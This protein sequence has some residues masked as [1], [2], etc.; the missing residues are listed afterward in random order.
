MRISDWSSDVCSSDL[1]AL[2]HLGQGFGKQINIAALVVGRKVAT[3]N[4]LTHRSQ[5]RFKLDD[6]IGSDNA[7]VHPKIAHDP[8]HSL[9]VLELGLIAVKI[10]YAALKVLVLDAQFPEHA[11]QSASTV[12]RHTH[13]GAYVGRQPAGQALA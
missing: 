5:G 2:G 7:A 12:F 1:G 8:R 10:K 4:A 6:F 13:H 3:H 11:L 9:A